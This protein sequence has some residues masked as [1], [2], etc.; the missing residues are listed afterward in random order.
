MRKNNKKSYQMRKAYLNVIRLAFLV[1][2][3]SIVTGS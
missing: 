1:I 3:I 2:I